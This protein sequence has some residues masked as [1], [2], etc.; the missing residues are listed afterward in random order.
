MIRF[1]QLDSALSHTL[2]SAAGALLCA[3]VLIAAAV[4][5]SPI[6]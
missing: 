5:L 2:A 6:A 4:P 1:A 3:A